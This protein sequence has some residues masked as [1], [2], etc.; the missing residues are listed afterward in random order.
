MFCILSLTLLGFGFLTPLSASPSRSVVTNTSLKYLN[1]DL[2]YLNTG[3][4]HIL[5]CID[6]LTESLRH[7]GNNKGLSTLVTIVDEKYS[8]PQYCIFYSFY[9]VQS[10]RTTTIVAVFGDYRRQ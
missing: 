5:D 8:W 1:T 4:I 7:K 3:S 9:T 6:R 10:L 2:K